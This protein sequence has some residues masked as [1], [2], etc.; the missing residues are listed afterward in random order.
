MKLR[1]YSKEVAEI[2]RQ[3]NDVNNNFN[4]NNMPEPDTDFNVFLND[5]IPPPLLNEQ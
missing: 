1:S 2:T 3:L 4:N 5:F